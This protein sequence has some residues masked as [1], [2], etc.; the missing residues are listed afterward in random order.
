MKGD[1]MKLLYERLDSAK[2]DLE[3]WI[4]ENPDEKPDREIHELADLAVPCYTS[5]V[6]ALAPDIPADCWNDDDRSKCEAMVAKAA[7]AYF[8]QSLQ[9]QRMIADAARFT[10]GMDA[11]QMDDLE[12][13]LGLA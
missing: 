9:R 12:R 4:K 11:D 2:Y 8:T 1:N 10:E 3:N 5:D 6:L 7:N 13:E